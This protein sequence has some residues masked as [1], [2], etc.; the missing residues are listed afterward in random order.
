MAGGSLNIKSGKSSASA[1]GPTVVES[2]VST[3]GNG[4]Q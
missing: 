3:N 4:G 2:G 1:G